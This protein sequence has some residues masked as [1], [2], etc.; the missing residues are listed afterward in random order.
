MGWP[1]PGSGGL[2]VLGFRSQAGQ[3]LKLRGVGP[4]GTEAQNSGYGM[5]WLKG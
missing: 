3:T 1:L 2:E 4:H 5:L